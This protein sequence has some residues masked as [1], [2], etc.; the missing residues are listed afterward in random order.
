[1]AFF[2]NI[3]DPCNVRPEDRNDCGWYGIDENTCK[4]RGCC[5]DDTI[6]GVNAKWCFYPTGYY[7][8]LRVR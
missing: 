3:A 7:N 6:Y 4:G 8:F 5:Y 1:M 2:V